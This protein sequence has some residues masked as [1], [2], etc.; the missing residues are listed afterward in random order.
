MRIDCH[1]HVN[2]LGY[3]AK[4][5]IGHYDS[6]GIDKVWL[7]TWEEVNGLTF[8]YQHLCFEDMWAAYKR[9]PARIIPFYAPDPRRPDAERALREAIKKGIKG[10][11]ECKVRVCLE[12]PD[13]N[14]LFRI[15]GDAGL[16]VLIHMDKPLPPNFDYWYNYGIDGLGRVLEALPNTNFVGHGP[17]FWRYVSGDEDH[18]MSEYPKGKVKPGGKL[19]KLLNRHKNLWCDIS[20]GSGL[21]AISRDREWGKKF[22]INYCDRIL[23]GTDCFDRTHLDYLEGLNLD[24]RV[25]RK[26][27]GENAMSLT[28]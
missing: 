24:A 10:F 1:I 25:M 27:M 17:G 4:K 18:N 9:Y 6:L 16:P 20:A 19:L 12:D 14:K 26:I 5:L 11:G 3:D 13:L 23:Y 8:H 7:L 22:L 15:A 28:H 2:W 21:G